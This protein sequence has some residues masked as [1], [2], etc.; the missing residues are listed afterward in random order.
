MASIAQIEANRRNSQKSTGP[1][2]TAGKAVSSMNALKSG[3]DAKSQVIRGED[4]KDLEALKT[5]YYESLKPT[6][7]EE[8]LLVDAIIASDWLLRRFRKVEAETWEKAFEEQDDW[9]ERYEEDV[10]QPM[11]RA[12][13]SKQWSLARLQR[14]LDAAERT[15]HRSLAELRRIRTPQ[16]D[17]DPPPVNP[18]PDEVKPKIGFVPQHTTDPVPVHLSKT[19]FSA[20]FST[21]P[22]LHLEKDPPNSLKPLPIL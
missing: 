18:L 17:P 6:R 7:P 19:A 3:I 1:R 11:A 15:I 12:F 14:R 16:P 4:P 8:A 5:S 10:T 2:T 21:A 9:S 20:P 13:E 22:R